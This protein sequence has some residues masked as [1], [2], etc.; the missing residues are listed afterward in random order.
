MSPARR[1]RVIDLGPVYL[2]VV[3]TLLLVALGLGFRVLRGIVREGRDR[4][5]RRRAGEMEKYTEDEEYGRRPSAGSEGD[6]AEDGGRGDSNGPAATCPSCGAANESGFSYCR[7]CTA[8]LR[9]GP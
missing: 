1:V 8:P 7:R 6:R 3:G 5:A 9:P 2:A 4:R